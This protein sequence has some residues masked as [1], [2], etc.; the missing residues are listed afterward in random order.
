MSELWMRRLIFQAYCFVAGVAAGK[1]VPMAHDQVRAGY[2]LSAALLIFSLLGFVRARRGRFPVL[3]AAFLFGFCCFFLGWARYSAAVSVQDPA[4]ISKFTSDSWKDRSSVEGVVLTDPEVF[5]DRLKFTVGPL[6]AKRE[7]RESEFEEISGGRVE[8]TILRTAKELYFDFARGDIYGWRI[9]VNAPLLAPPG[10]VNPYGFSYRDF[11]ADQD[12]YAVQTVSVAWGSPPPIEVLDRGEGFFLKEWAIALKE[13]I[14]SVF[15]RTVPY[16]QSAFLAGVTLGYDAVL[17]KTLCV[18]PGHGK[19]VL[20]ECR[21]AG[22]THVLAVSGQHVTILSG[23]LLAILSALR[24]PMRVQAP[25]IILVL[26]IFLIM[27]GLPPSAMRATLMNSF[28]IFFL[29]LSRGSF[30][31]SV[32]FG[33]AEAAMI[34]LFV[35]PKNIVQPSFTLSFAAILSLALLTKPVDRLL[36]GLRGPTFVYAV[37][38]AAV[39]T[40]MC[41]TPYFETFAKPAVHL[42]LLSVFAAGLIWVHK[43]NPAGPSYDRL[44]EW[45]RLFISAQGAILLGMMFP[46]S[47]YYFGRFALAGPY[48]NLIAIPLTGL[49]VPIGLIAGII[50]MVPGFG[51]FLAL[52]LNAANNCLILLFFYAAHYSAVWFPYPFVE[53]L[54]LGRLGLY[55]AVLA[56]FAWWEPIHSHGRD[57]FY[58]YYKNA[59]TGPRAAALR[60]NLIG[61][62]AGSALFLA[63]I[64]GKVWVRPPAAPEGTLRVTFLS[65][66]FGSAAAVQS[67]FG[68]TFLIDGGLNNPGGPSDVGE[69]V[70]APFLLKQ[71]ITSIDAVVLTNLGPEH[72]EGLATIVDGFAVREIYDPAPIRDWNRFAA[73]T[74]S[75]SEKAYTMFLKDL[76]DPDLKISRSKPHVRRMYEGYARLVRSAVRRGI[77]RRQAAPGREIE[78]IPAGPDGGHGPFR[79]GFLG[80]RV[81][82]RNVRDQSA[83]MKVEYGEFSVVFTGDAGP[84]ALDR[85]IQD[86]GQELRS[87]VMV[88]PN[89]GRVPADRLSAWL[90]AVR[91]EAVIFQ[92]GNFKLLYGK[93]REAKALVDES[94]QE[95][96]VCLSACQDRLGADRVFDTS[97]DWAVVIES[98]GGEFKARSFKGRSLQ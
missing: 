22:V 6:R 65:T 55:Y 42:P 60:R 71:G 5:A 89:H 56:V 62:S 97:R 33:I 9:R 21:I 13:K 54:T 37:L 25:V 53:N 84:D 28:T 39:L 1:L 52:I 58:K 93:S 24:I 32:L 40:M 59:G 90:D 45:A 67:P 18:V 3:A 92:S 70:L 12:I 47:S 72:T 26:F 16:P 10:E 15:V 27:T 50:G 4:H 8:V 98:D 85:L 78:Q 34:V 86:A 48:A 61:I 76:G 41:T 46:L 49:I 83:I 74:V 19:W 20:D 44:P 81:H 73:L 57:L 23:V 82:H 64:A 69:R 11:L 17:Q 95:Y 31:A 94:K 91:P 75:D 36:S 38:G 35:N 7:G 63:L 43:K 14:L 77:V 30:R 2:A 29:A 96:D 80:P 51:F 68:K 88:I 87:D 79:A 66:S